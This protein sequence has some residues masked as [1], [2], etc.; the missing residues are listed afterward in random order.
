M[1]KKIMLSVLSAALVGAGLLTVNQVSAQEATIN[2][3]DSL[4]Q[5]LG[6]KFGLNETK[7]KQVFKEVHEARHAEM[8]KHMEDRL[9]QAVNDRKL[10][11][12]QKQNILAKHEEMKANREQTMESFKKMT[13]AERRTA[14]KTKHQEL[15]TWAE[16][17]DIPMEY[18][19]FRM[20]AMKGVHRGDFHMKI[21]D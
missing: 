5:R 3:H 16:D 1:N 20:K 8:S 12:E 14:I 7:V 11:E 9:S 21:A 13:K 2:P 4:I 10:T 18:F 17:N 19:I 15:R 6:G